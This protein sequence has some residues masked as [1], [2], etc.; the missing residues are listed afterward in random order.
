MLFVT[1]QVFFVQSL[2]LVCHFAEVLVLQLLQVT[3]ILKGLR[4]LLLNVLLLQLS[5]HF[6]FL[7]LTNLQGHYFLFKL[8]LLF[9]PIFFKLLEL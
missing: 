8:A 2:L 5:L 3:L 1:V 7:L 4:I 9:D 6:L